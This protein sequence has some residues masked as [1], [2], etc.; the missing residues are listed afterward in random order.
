MPAVAIS[1]NIGKI[2][3]SNIVSTPATTGMGTKTKRVFKASPVTSMKFVTISS[4][5][6]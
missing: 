5:L 2:V 1:I 4:M 3:K 6:S